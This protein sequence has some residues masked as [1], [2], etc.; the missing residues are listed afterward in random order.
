VLLSAMAT[1]EECRESA[2]KLIHH[3]AEG[4]LIKTSDSS[5]ALATS[6]NSGLLS[7][8]FDNP[9]SCTCRP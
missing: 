1:P 2:L 9:S 8:L 6:A 3:L 7:G 5:I 4:G